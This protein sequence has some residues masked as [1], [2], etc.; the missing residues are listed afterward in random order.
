[1]VGYKGDAGSIAQCL[2]DPEF[3]ARTKI[4]AQFL[5]E[6]LPANSLHSFYKFYF[7]RVETLPQ[8]IPSHTFKVVP[9]IGNPDPF[10]RLTWQELDSAVIQV[11]VTL[12]NDF[13][14]IE[15]LL[16]V[17]QG[18]AVGMLPVISQLSREEIKL[19]WERILNPTIDH[20]TGLGHNGN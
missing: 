14:A 2:T 13:W 1:M 20:M 4:L 8:K 15:L 10:D 17:A 7:V 19:K 5:F 12:A 11:D 6:P 3:T 18:I 9:C 16:H